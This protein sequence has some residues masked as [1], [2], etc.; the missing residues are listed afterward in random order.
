MWGGKLVSRGSLLSCT[1]RARAGSQVLPQTPPHPSAGTHL[2]SDRLR[3]LESWRRRSTA[4]GMSSQPVRCRACRLPQRSASSA[5]AASSAPVWLRSSQRRVTAAGPAA[6]AET[7]AEV[8]RAHP[9]AASARS[10]GMPAAARHASSAAVPLMSRWCKAG[11]LAAA[12]VSSAADTA[13]TAGQAQ[14]RQRLQRAQA[15][16]VAVGH[17]AGAA[18]PQAAQRA[19]VAAQ[20]RGK[21]PRR[22]RPLPALGSRRASAAGGL[23]LLPV[24]EGSSSKLS[25][26]RAPEEKQSGRCHDGCAYVAPVVGSASRQQLDRSRRSSRPAG[27]AATNAVHTRSGSAEPA[28]GEAGQAAE[29]LRRLTQVALVTRCQP[30]VCWPWHLPRRASGAAATEA[31]AAARGAQVE[32][33][34]GA[35]I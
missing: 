23:T 16:E 8:Q 35:E 30:A 5:A 14:V 12:S 33:A 4:A 22:S 34:A 21:A 15:A 11:Q 28:A 20:R 3:R 29:A 32:C 1:L 25:D 9:A 31:A 27:A 2:P 7:P 17:A 18:Q 19:A 6:R 24:T 26:R 13:V 10:G